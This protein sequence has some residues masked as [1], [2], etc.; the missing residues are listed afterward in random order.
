[1]QALSLSPTYCLILRKFINCFKPQFSYLSCT[2]WKANS[3][4]M[5]GKEWVLNNGNFDD[6]DDALILH[7]SSKL[8]TVNN[9][10]LCLIS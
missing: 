3:C 7:S 9:A 10:T 8:N 4:K 6:Y 5:P 1:M 2:L